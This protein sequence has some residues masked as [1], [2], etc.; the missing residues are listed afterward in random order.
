MGA[1]FLGSLTPVFYLYLHRAE[2]VPGGS[3]VSSEGTSHF[4][5]AVPS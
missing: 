4:G 1:Y 5:R 2:R 3:E